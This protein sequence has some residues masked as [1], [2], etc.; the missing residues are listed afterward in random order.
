[1]YGRFLFEEKKETNCCDLYRKKWKA[2]RD[3]MKP[4][5]RIQIFNSLLRLVQ[6]NRKHWKRH[7]IHYRLMIIEINDR[8]KQQRKK[9]EMKTK[10]AN[11]L[12]HASCPCCLYVCLYC[13]KWWWAL[14][15]IGSIF[16]KN[17]IISVCMLVFVYE[18]EAKK[19]WCTKFFHILY[20]YQA[21]I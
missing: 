2:T 7:G 14:C 11:E 18:N 5:K 16:V 17:A 6:E 4:N 1:M 8:K 20:L 12:N 19:Y 10:W 3:N 15:K 21:H 9:R 13:V